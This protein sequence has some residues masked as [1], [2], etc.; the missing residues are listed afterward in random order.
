[1]IRVS[2]PSGGGFADTHYL[3]GWSNSNFVTAAA[4]LSNFL[5]QG[6]AWSFGFRAVGSVPGDNTSITSFS[7]DNGAVANSN[8]SGFIWNSFMYSNTNAGGTDSFQTIPT[9]TAVNYW[10]YSYDGTTLTIYYNGTSISTSTVDGALPTTTS[11][12][13]AFGKAINGGRDPWASAVGVSAMYFSNEALAQS[14]NTTATNNNG[15][16]TSDSEYSKVDGFINVGNGTLT[17]AKSAYSP[18]VSGTL[19]YTAK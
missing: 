18:S 15:D 2:T 5:T 3:T 16:I 13:V 19:T 17:D 9:E 8:F 11:G 1:M 7:T 14:I 6:N 10:L 12:N 4:G